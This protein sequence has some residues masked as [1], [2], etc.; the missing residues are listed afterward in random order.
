M[1]LFLLFRLSIVLPVILSGAGIVYTMTAHDL[2]S[3]DWQDLMAWNGNGGILPDD[4]SLAPPQVWLIIGAIGSTAA[5]AL[6]NQV[7]LFFYWKP[8]RTIFLV[9]C[10]LLYP[11][12]LLLGLTILTPV[13]YLLFE[14]SALFTGV[15]LALV[16]YT[17]VA[18]RFTN[19]ETE[20]DAPFSR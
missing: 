7:L 2:F 6:V 13:E 4:L 16:Y 12:M 10:A 14:L 8:S 17:P 3:Q 5:I 18:N 9:S 1:N 20:Q 19:K 11:A 15:T